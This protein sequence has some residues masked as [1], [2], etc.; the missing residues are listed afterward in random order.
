MFVLEVMKKMMKLLLNMMLFL[1][2]VWQVCGAMHCYFSSDTV[3]FTSM[4]DSL[5]CHC[6][7]DSE[8][9]SWSSMVE[10]VEKDLLASIV[11]VTIFNCSTLF[12]NLTTTQSHLFLLP[13]LTVSTAD[14]VFP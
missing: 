2:M 11:D 1:M 9:F 12:I 4:P 13:N 5:T 14:H 3:R 10:M 7:G 8:I 6:E